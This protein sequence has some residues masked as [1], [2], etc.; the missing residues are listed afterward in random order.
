MI[1]L[2]IAGP[3][4]SRAPGT[5][6]GRP[7][8]WI[9]GDAARGVYRLEIN[10]RPAVAKTLELVRPD[11]TKGLLR[12]HTAHGRSLTAEIDLMRS[13]H[14]RP[15][16]HV[17]KYLG[18]EHEGCRSVLLLAWHGEQTIHSYVRSKP[19]SWLEAVL[20]T[21]QI[22]QALEHLRGYGPHGLVHRDIKPS[23]IVLTLGGDAVLI[24][25]GVATPEPHIYTDVAWGSPGY[26]A[27]EVTLGGCPSTASDVYSLGVTMV[28][29]LS[30]PIYR[31]RPDESIVQYCVRCADQPPPSLT[32]RFAPVPQLE[33]IPGEFTELLQ[34]CLEPKPAQRP[35]PS[36]MIA[37]TADLLTTHGHG[38]P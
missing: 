2:A 4:P 23:N 30:G 29:A 20:W 8:Q 28:E 25:F 14:W 36:D 32:D 21:H 15:H 17:V 22:A 16:P 12:Q 24:D 37:V 38:R 27:P 7:A 26:I 1:R 9:A 3:V 18:V 31:Q 19:V 5:I 33:G 6:L 35:T 10:G 34:R 11:A 13:S